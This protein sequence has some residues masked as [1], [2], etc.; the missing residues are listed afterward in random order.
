MTDATIGIYT[1]STVFAALGVLEIGDRNPAYVWWLTLVLGL[2]ITIPT[3]LT[4]LADWLSIDRST[5]LWR[6][7]T[8]HMI[9]MLTATAFF[10]L[11]AL[12]GHDGYKRGAV[13]GLP[14]VLTIVG[15]GLLTLGGWLGGSV[16]YVHGMRVLNLLTEPARRATAP[17]AHP[18]KEEAEGG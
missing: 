8:S 18:E 3:A 10:A 16:V 7:A 5:P 12:L 13:E 15:F 9:A 4:G 11:A 14:F 2:I 17:V 6:T 1:A